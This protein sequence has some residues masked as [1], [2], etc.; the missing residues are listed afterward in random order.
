MKD[1][2]L[3]F[4]IASGTTLFWPGK[5]DD[6]YLFHKSKVMNRRRNGRI[7]LSCANDKGPH[8]PHEVLP[9]ESNASCTKLVDVLLGC[10]FYNWTMVGN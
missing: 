3:A 1:V 2:E 8:V 4:P 6:E 10:H 7:I 9:G 5:K